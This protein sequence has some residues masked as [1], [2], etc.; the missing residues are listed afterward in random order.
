MGQPPVVRE[1]LKVVLKGS[2]ILSTPIN[3]VKHRFGQSGFSQPSEV[4]NGV[5]VRGIFRDRKCRHVVFNAK[6]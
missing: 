5:T 3:E 6:S 1:G 4:S 2:L